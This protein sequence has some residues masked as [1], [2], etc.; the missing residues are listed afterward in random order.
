M[1]KYNIEFQGVYIEEIEANSL[2][3]A[4]EA[5]ASLLYQLEEG[6]SFPTTW[7]VSSIKETE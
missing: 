5:A 3:D 6:S 4:R 7:Y 1:P 2:E